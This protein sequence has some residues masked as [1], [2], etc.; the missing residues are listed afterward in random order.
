MSNNPYYHRLLGFQSSNIKS[1]VERI[2]EWM[3]ALEFHKPYAKLGYEESATLVGEYE[4]KINE[5]L[6]KIIEAAATVVMTDV[7]KEE[8]QK[9]YDR[10]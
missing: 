9:I 6:D 4:K 5:A 2:K 10:Y 1:K 8:L 7:T 3:G